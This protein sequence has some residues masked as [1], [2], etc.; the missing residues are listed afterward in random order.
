VRKG[1]DLLERLPL[2]SAQLVFGRHPDCGV[3]MDHASI[4]R[5]HAV[6]HAPAP[7]GAGF[8]LE[9]AGSAHG[10]FVNGRRLAS[11]AAQPLK[12]GDVIRFGA[13]P[14]AAAAAA[15]RRTVGASL[16]PARRSRACVRS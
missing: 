7:G 14:S 1:A 2:N 3:R 6:L 4:S 9:D 8:A 10:T 5:R 16:P 11:G 15:C 12:G 13:A